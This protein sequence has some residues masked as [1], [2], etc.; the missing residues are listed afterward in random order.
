MAAI[1]VFALILVIAV[2]LARDV[3]V[4]GEEAGGRGAPPG[5]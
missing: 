4:F 1:A 3:S 2:R 5:K